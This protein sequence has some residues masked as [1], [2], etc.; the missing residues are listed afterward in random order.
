MSISDGVSASMVAPS[1]TGWDPDGPVGPDLI[2][3][4]IADEQLE[5]VAGPAP[6]AVGGVQAIAVEVTSALSLDLVLLIGEGMPVWPDEI[7]RVVA[8]PR[9]GGGVPDVI[10]VELDSPCEA[11]YDSIEIVPAG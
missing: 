6:V 2:D 1:A 4:I 9:P 10:M 3:R 7:V 5:V 11:V 8:I